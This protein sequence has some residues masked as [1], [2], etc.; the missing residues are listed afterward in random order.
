MAAVRARVGAGAS[1]TS[2]VPARVEV[3]TGRRVFSDGV[4]T[5]EI[6]ETGPGPHAEEMLVAWIPAEGI[7]FQGDLIDVGSS[8]AVLPGTNNE[9]TMHFARWVRDRGWT[10]KLFAGAHGFLRG[11]ADFAQ[12]LRQPVGSAA[13]TD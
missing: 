13:P 7:L 6:H 9:T 8:G 3:V 5:V 11:P 1:P 12:L 2:A 10:V 4:R